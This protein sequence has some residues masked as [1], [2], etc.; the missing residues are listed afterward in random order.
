MLPQQPAAHTRHSSPW[1]AA[2]ITLN[3]KRTSGRYG[4]WSGQVDVGAVARLAGGAAFAGAVKAAHHWVCKACRRGW[5]LKVIARYT[6]R[7]IH[8][9]RAYAACA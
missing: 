4:S 7:A 3:R 8:A 5:D 2:C 1:P 6:N 9:A